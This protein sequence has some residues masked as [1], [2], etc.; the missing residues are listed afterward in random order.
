[1]TSSNA[2]FSNLRVAAFESRRAVEMERLIERM[3]GV[4]LVSA[5]MR[6]VV[7][8]EDRSSID[9]AKS[10]DYRPSRRCDFSY[11][12]WHTYVGRAHRTTCKTSAIF[13]CAH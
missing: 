5:S 9:F 11:W 12:R 8:E 10:L 13:G 6:E 1:M 2:S 3:Q 4:P 7:I